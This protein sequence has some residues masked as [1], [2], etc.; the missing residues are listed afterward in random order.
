M[1]EEQRISD[2][3]RRIAELEKL[4][5]QARSSATL[6]EVALANRRIL[7]VQIEKLATKLELNDKPQFF[8]GACPLDQTDIPGLF[9]SL[10]SPANKL[11]EYPPKLR[12]N[13]FT[14]YDSQQQSVIVDGNARE[15]LFRS[16]GRR[17]TRFGAFTALFRG[18]DDFLGW[19]MR[20]QGWPI[21]GAQKNTPWR[22]NS[23]V[24]IESTR[25]CVNL[26]IELSKFGSPLPQSIQFVIGFK[27]LLWHNKG[28]LLLDGKADVN[29]PFR[30]QV[31]TETGECFFSITAKLDESPERIAFRLVA[32]IYHLF[33]LTDDRIPYT[34]WDGKERS[35]D[36]AQ[37]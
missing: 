12:E 2:L 20:S 33:N 37:F 9:E 16:Q 7:E 35:I 31:P 24:L 6:N 3:E 11:F 34:K 5:I 25:N 10:S 8:V 27:N 15:L 17:I 19:A 1:T 26:A 23:L 32:E 21:T 29:M 13:G 28:P 4:L 14:L 30:Q 22:I 18:D 36:I